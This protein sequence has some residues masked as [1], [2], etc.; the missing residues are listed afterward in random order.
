MEQ[1]RK[2]FDALWEQEERQGLQWR[3]R[4]DYPAWMRRRRTRRGALASIAVLIVAAVSI[5][6]FQI[7]ITK[8]YDTV[9]CNRTS[10]TDSHWAEVAA[11][12][13]TMETL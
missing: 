12:I 11:N 2:T 6:N 3:L 8:P 9:V 1:N 4:Q 7:S 13:L 10:F 5:F